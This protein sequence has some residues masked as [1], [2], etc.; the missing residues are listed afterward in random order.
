VLFVVDAVIC[1]FGRLGDWFGT[2]RFGITPDLITFAKGVTS[3]VQPLGGV[4]AS[5]A[6]AAPFWETPGHV[7]RHGQTYAGHPAACAAGLAT[8]QLYEREGLFAR[9]D[10]LEGPLFE[11]LQGLA[12]HPLVDH[13]RGGVGFLGALELVPRPGITGLVADAARGHG[14]II[15]PMVSA[16]GFSPPLTATEEH[17]DLLVDGVRKGLD[18]VASGM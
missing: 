14:V 10:A 15:R 1:G 17:L 2:E 18:Q 6:V 16:L 9:A 7:F 4:V 11:R 13:A 12:D 8:V 5:G 3:G